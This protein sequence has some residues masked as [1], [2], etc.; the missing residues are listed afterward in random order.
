MLFANKQGFLVG[1]ECDVSNL[2]HEVGKRK[3][4]DRSY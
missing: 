1:R 3:E 2:L 4:S